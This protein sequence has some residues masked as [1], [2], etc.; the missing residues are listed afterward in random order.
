M[1]KG[2]KALSRSI[3]NK[4]IIKNV[5]EPAFVRDVFQNSFV[6]KHSVRLPEHCFQFRHL[7][8]NSY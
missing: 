8:F 5:F 2:D 6:E 7:E 3:I 1:Q 4:S